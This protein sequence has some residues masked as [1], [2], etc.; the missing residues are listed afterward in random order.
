[1]IQDAS[2]SR[3]LSSD[4]VFQE[5]SARQSSGAEQWL[6]RHTEA[7]SSWPSWPEASYAAL[8]RLHQVVQDD[9][10]SLQ[11]YLAHKKTPTPLGPHSAL[12]M[13]LL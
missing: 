12:G 7:G 13:V 8:P 2:E 3:G 1:M 5:T 11:G 10:E 4:D 6:Q 9:S